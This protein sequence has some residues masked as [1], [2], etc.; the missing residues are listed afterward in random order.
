ML[1]HSPLIVRPRPSPRAGDTLMHRGNISVFIC[2]VSGMIL[3][4]HMSISLRFCVCVYICVC[5]C[6]CVCSGDRLKKDLSY[7]LSQCFQKGS[8]DQR[9]QES[10]RNNLH[11]YSTP[12]ESSRN[13]KHTPEP[14]AR[15]SELSLLGLG[16]VWFFF[17]TG[18]KSIL[19]K[20][21]R[22]LNGA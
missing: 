20:R 8:A 1:R 9:Q 4:V 7:F 13:T 21:Y 15:N 5:V 10:I 12:C 16:I 2:S 22:C 6:V 3:Y 17:D 14:S 11:R 19:L 18:A